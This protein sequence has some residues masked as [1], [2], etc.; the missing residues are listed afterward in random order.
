MSDKNQKN[1][2]GDG[3]QPAPN[4]PK[5]SIPQPGAGYQPT[6]SG[7]NNPANPNRPPKKP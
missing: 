3:Y 1:I 7:G 5:T 2:I 6:K 4:N